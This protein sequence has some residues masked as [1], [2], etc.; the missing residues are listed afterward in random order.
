MKL[1]KKLLILFYKNK[2]ILLPILLTLTLSPFTY[3][4]DLLFFNNQEIPDLKKEL[5]EFKEEINFENLNLNEKQDLN[6]E[7]NKDLNFENLNLNE[8]QDLNFEKNKDL[9]FE[10]KQ[11]SKKTPNNLSKYFIV[12]SFIVLIVVIIYTSGGGGGDPSVFDQM[13][14]QIGEINALNAITDEATKNI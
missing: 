7:E 6:F 2:K 12:S 9:N 10:E 1:L 13:I 5:I 11:D 14:K 3:F 4:L 8:K